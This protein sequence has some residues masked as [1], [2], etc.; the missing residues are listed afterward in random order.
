ME[1]EVEH[2]FRLPWAHLIVHLCGDK[3]KSLCGFKSGNERSLP[4][5]SLGLMGSQT[6]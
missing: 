2:E 1:T 4:V 5:A 6:S 3:V